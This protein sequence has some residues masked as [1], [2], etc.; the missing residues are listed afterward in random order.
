MS[1]DADF[2]VDRR[3][4]R[5]KLFFWRLAAFI[6]L[7]AALVA[8]GIGFAGDGLV[9]KGRPHIARVS[10][11]GLIT[12]DRKVLT[13]LD[14]LGRND[15]VAGVIVAIDSPGGTT[16]GGEELYTALRRLAADKPVVAE[17]STLAAS[18]GYMVAIAADHIV[19]ERTTIT[20]S[21]GVL[22]QY[23][24]VGGLLD[25]IGVEVKTIKSAPLKAEPSPFTYPEQP[26]AAEMIGRLVNDTFEW[27][28]DI[29]AERRGLKREDALKLADGSV[30]S[31]RQALELGLVDGIGGE[32]EA[33]AWL[34]ESRGVAKDL[35][36]LD[37]APPAP[38]EPLSLVGRA[39]GRLVGLDL[40]ALPAQASLD[41]LIS[42]WH[43]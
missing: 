1:F 36:V 3:R 27:F 9:A 32:R 33:I 15:A 7:A 13:M 35:P 29:V 43:P 16:A 22:F 34:E 5:R 21:I 12:S 40:S 25:K 18:A 19:A 24:N 26:G 11:N 4:T 28:V 14:G 38:F 8:I 37:W 41:G 6:A 17:M 2:L 42:V 10:V 39:A 20:G 23:G 30:Y 31:G